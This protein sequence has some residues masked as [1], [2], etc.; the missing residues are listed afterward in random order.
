MKRPKGLTGRD[1]KVGGSDRPSA[2]EGDDTRTLPPGY[3]LQP[4][5]SGFFSI[6]NWVSPL[7][8]TSVVARP[9]GRGMEQRVDEVGGS[10]SRPVIRRIG[11]QERRYPTRKGANFRLVLAVRKLS[12]AF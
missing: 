2:D 3:R 6:D 7:L 9:Q 12:K 5:R 8:P 4:N 1:Q 10:E 11:P